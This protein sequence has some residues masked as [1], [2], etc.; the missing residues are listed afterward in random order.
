[1][2]LHPLGQLTVS[3]S[4]VPLDMDISRFGDAAPAGA[5]RFTIRTASPGWQTLQ[6][7]R[8]FFAPA[9]FF[10]MSDAEKLSRPSFESMPAGVSLGSEG[11]SISAGADDWLE[12]PAIQFETIIVGQEQDS[13]E[14]TPPK[15]VYQLSPLLLGKQ[16]RFGAAAN[17]VLR[18]TGTAKYRTTAGKHQ[19]A[20]KGWSIVSTD[21]LK[22]QAVPGIE[23]RTVSYSEAEQALRKLKQQDPAK[24]SGLKILRLFEVQGSE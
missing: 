19:V 14:P 24:A 4:V 18:R 2:Q 17:S 13:G 20:K 16:A 10:E 21:D 12:V 11:F 1:M 22:V 7:V 5:R 6:A 9:Q 3:Q 8:E 23:E 15:D